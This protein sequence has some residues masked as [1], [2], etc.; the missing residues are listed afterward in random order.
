MEA[1]TERQRQALEVIE[2]MLVG[3]N[4]PSQRQL[5][6]ALGLTQTAVRQLIGYLKAK[7]YLV[8]VGGHRGLRLSD[9]YKAHAHG[10]PIIGRVAAGRPILAQECIEGYLQVDRLFGSGLFALKVI[11]DS[12]VDDGIMDGDYVLV[13]PTEQIED[14][15]IGV[16]LLDDEVTIKRVYRTGDRLLLRPANRRARYRSISV[17]PSDRHVRLIGQVVGC[18]RTQVR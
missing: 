5:A 7:G 8:D 1:L 4:P 16:V 2:R 12:M 11:G 14:G 3:G 15:R 17:R 18:I 6:K 10:I 13:R 9:A